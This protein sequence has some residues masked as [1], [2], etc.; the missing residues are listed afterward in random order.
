MTVRSWL[1]ASF[2]ADNQQKRLVSTATITIGIFMTPALLSVLVATLNWNA[3]IPAQRA[4]ST[5]TVKQGIV[6]IATSNP[7]NHLAGLKMTTGDKG[8]KGFYLDRGIYTSWRFNGSKGSDSLTFGS[9][10]VIISKRDGGIVDFKNDKAKDV[11][12]FTNRIDGGGTNNSLNVFIGTGFASP[13][14]TN[15]SGCSLNTNGIASFSASSMSTLRCNRRTDDGRVID[16]L[17]AG[18]IEG[19]INVNGTTVSLV[20]GHISRW[21]QV[22][23]IGNDSKEDRPLILRGTVMTNL[24][25]MC[26]WN[27]PDSGDLLDNDQLNKTK[28]SDIEGDPNVAGVFESWDNDDNTWINDYH[29]AMTGDFIIRIAENVTIQRGDL[30]MSAGDGTAKPQGDDIIR[31]K[32]IAKVISMHI[33]CT[34]DDG[35]YCVPCVLM[36]C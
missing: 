13:A 33:T 36:S 12:T 20:G 28:S 4:Y 29:L 11:F 10:G 16:I 3:L 32:T 27:D 21:S 15:V 24:D 19:G 5:F 35:S 30:L 14:N 34:Y 6:S 25:E 18:N 22:V 8:I 9:Q 26:E 17:S 23:N 7:T 1:L 31:S 2:T